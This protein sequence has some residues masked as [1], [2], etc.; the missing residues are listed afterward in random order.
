V[1]LTITRNFGQAIKLQ[2]K[3]PDPESQ[4]QTGQPPA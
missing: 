2:P 1:F 4:A 3:Q